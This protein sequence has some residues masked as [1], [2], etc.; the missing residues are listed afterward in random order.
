MRKYG[1]LLNEQHG[2]SF[3]QLFLPNDFHT[4]FI[5]EIVCHF[6]WWEWCIDITI[7]VKTLDCAVLMYFE[8]SLCE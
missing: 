4:I 7:A 6:S 8:S 5:T 3:V 1:G 2:L